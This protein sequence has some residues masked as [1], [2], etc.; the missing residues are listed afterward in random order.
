MNGFIDRLFMD[1]NGDYHVHELKTGLWKDKK[2]KYDSMAKEMAFY[3][4]MLR[5]SSQLELGGVNISYWGWDHTKGIEGKP[6]EI[7]RFIEPVKAGVVA[8]MLTDLKALVSAHLRYKGDF[9]GKMFATKP[10]G[11][12]RYFC[13]PWCAVKGFCPKYERH[14]MPHEMRDK[15]EGN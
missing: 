2:M 10:V 9:N 12:E 4:Y 11:A 3:V 6:N 8:D 1:D 15:A 5:K 7:Y 14:M 13:Q